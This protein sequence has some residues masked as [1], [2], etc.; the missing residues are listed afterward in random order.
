M[1]LLTDVGEASWAGKNVFV[2]GVCGTIGSEL[3]R[4]LRMLDVARI[5]GIDIDEG[6]LF[7][8]IGKL[9]EDH[10]VEL[11]L[12]DIRSLESLAR[13]MRGSDIVIH[14]AAYKHVGIC[15]QAPNE[16]VSTNIT[17]TQ[18]VISA[19]FQ[20]NV[21]RVLLT[22]TD[23]AVNP[24]NVMGTSKL[25]A[26]RLITAASA[27]SRGARPIFSSIR[28]GNVVGSNGSVVP[29]FAG[30]IAAGGPVTLTDNEMTRFVMSLDQAVG[31]VMSATFLA[32]GGEVMVTKMPV[33]RIADLATSMIQYL[34]PRHGYEPARIPI[35]IIG[36][37]PGEKMFEELT[38]SEEVRRTFEW[39]NFLVVKP[40]F[41]GRG[42]NIFDDWERQGTPL[43]EPYN[44]ALLPAMPST[45][46]RA[47]FE[48]E[49]LGSRNGV[50]DA[51]GSAACA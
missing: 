4:R 45:D 20:N 21:E 11:V 9:G 47:Y 49:E 5:V 29:L 48:S 50:A 7:E 34:A 15:E 12:C 40:P 46:V 6:A 23:K 19:A 36:S 28:F 38:N 44:S 24:T 8:L 42:V 37:R 10:R 16:A 30:Q 14:A 13:I 1:S 3:L 41:S 51:V 39:Q 33:M 31:L 43:R 2:T 26:E 32:R 18:N 35:R 22:S 27:N 25:M 17:G